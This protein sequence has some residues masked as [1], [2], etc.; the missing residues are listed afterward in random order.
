MFSNS[1]I[2]DFQLLMLPICRFRP[3]TLIMWHHKPTYTDTDLYKPYCAKPAQP[4]I[5]QFSWATR[6][7]TTCYNE[8]IPTAGQRKSHERV[9]RCSRCSLSASACR[10]AKPPGQIA[11]CGVFSNPATLRR[12]SWTYSRQAWRDFLNMVLWGFLRS[13]VSRDVKAIRLWRNHRCYW[14]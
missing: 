1:T 9:Y 13:S 10:I 14:L 3:V 5:K 12:L 2:E 8:P 6:I 4:S 7:S 11:H